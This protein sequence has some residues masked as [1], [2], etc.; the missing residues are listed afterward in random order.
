MKHFS[1]SLGPLRIESPINGVW[2]ARSLSE[3]LF[4]TLLVK[5]VDGVARRLRVAAETA[6][7]LVGV[8]APVA[9]DEDLASAQSEGIR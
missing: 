2:A 1:Q 7:Y 6:G 3:C 5:L 8:L 4:E 9:G